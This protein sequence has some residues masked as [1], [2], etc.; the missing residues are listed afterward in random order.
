ML[1]SK[2][3]ITKIQAPNKFQV[4][5]PNVQRKSPVFVVGIGIVFSRV[6][7]FR[8]SPFGYWLFGYWSLF[9]YCILVIDY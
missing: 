9:G 5:N 7:R 1:T 6:Y 8:P 3:P 2:S 4:P